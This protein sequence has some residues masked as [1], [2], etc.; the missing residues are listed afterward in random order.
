[1]KIRINGNV[2]YN[3]SICKVSC[4]GVL[5]EKGKRKSLVT[6]D[7]IDGDC[8]VCIFVNNKIIEMVT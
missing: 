5:E 2:N 7:I 3:G 1:M 6:L 8:N 4:Y